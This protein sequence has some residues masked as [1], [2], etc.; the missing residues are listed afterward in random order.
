MPQITHDDNSQVL[1]S[2]DTGLQRDVERA[3]QK[4]SEVFG[5][6]ATFHVTTF[7]DPEDTVP[8]SELALQVGYPHL[9]IQDALKCLRIFDEWWLVEPKDGRSRLIVDLHFC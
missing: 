3:I 4:C 8:I 1:L 5:E 9:S 7:T 6:K 2:S